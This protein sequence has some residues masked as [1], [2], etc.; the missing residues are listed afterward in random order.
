MKTRVLVAS[1][2]VG[3]ASAVSALAPA[4]AQADAN[5]GRYVAA[6]CAN[7]HGTNG[8]AKG[9]M[10]SLAGQKKEFITEQVRAFRDGKRPATLMHQISKGYTDAQIDAIADHFARQPAAR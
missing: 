1:T 6:N 7:C 5:A 2:F 3:L 10:P 4:L 9:A 8:V